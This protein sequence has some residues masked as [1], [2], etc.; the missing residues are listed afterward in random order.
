VVWLNAATGEGRLTLEEFTERA[1]EAYAART[2]GDL[3]RLVDDLPAPAPLAPVGV[4]GPPA[5]RV[6]HIIPVGPIKRRGR[7]RLDRDTEL[8]TVLGAIKL[9][10]RGAEIAA[11]EVEL[12]VHAVV[13]AVKVWIPDGIRTEVEGATVVGT[14]QVEE[15]NPSGHAAPLLRLRIDTVVGSVKVYR[16]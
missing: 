16:V 5:P 15:Y 12:V 4:A 7:W 10:L 8:G 14:R 11:P 2:R 1:G 9:D 3:V 6:R 13:G